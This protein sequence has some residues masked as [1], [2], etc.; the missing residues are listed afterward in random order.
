MTPVSGGPLTPDPPALSEVE[1]AAQMPQLDTP[2]G[3]A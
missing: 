3:T 1:A 2:N